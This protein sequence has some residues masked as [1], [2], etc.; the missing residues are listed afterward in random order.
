[1]RND[2]II[3]FY[4]YYVVYNFVSVTNNGNIVNTGSSVLEF[5]VPFDALNKK[6]IL[7]LQQKISKD[8]GCSQCVITNIIPLAQNYKDK[9]INTQSISNVKL[10]GKWTPII[11]A[12]GELVEFICDCGC[13]SQAAHNY[14]PDCGMKMDNSDIEKRI[15]DEI[16]KNI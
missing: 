9:K 11:N 5:S 1:M 3:N 10:E 4:E 8:I 2:N 15:N 6:A 13:S 12:I 7:D 14:C 16:S